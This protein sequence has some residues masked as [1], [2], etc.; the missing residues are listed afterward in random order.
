VSAAT[1]N[2]ARSEVEFFIDRIEVHASNLKIAPDTDA[3]RHQ[4]FAALC[5]LPDWLLHEVDPAGGNYPSAMF[6][7][8]EMRQIVTYRGQVYSAVADDRFTVRAVPLNAA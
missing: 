7:A 8:G 1:H 4:I 6:L 3:S 5:P 2:C